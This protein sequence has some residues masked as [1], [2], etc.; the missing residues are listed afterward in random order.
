MSAE[1]SWATCS[2]QWWPLWFLC[3]GTFTLGNSAYNL[4][5]KK[6]S[7]LSRKR[8]CDMFHTHQLSYTCIRKFLSSFVRQKHFVFWFCMHLRSDAVSRTELF[9]YV[10]TLPLSCIKQKPYICHEQ[11]ISNKRFVQV[12]HMSPVWTYVKAGKGDE[13]HFHYHTS[14][15]KRQTMDA[16]WK[17]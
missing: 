7:K 6:C 5:S 13:S 4:C 17:S 11:N 16:R 3:K 15:K 8:L 14:E 2:S 12:V 9:L 10:N 1:V